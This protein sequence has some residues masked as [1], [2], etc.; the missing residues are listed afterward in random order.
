MK[1]AI[2][3]KIKIPE[4]VNISVHGNEV[5]VKGN[6]GEIKKKLSLKNVEMKVE[7]DEFHCWS[8]K[9][10]KNEKKIVNTNIAHIKNMI[11]GVQEPY[12]YT[13]KIC[14]S[15]FPMTVEVKGTEV[16]LKNYLGEKY[17]RKTQIP[18]G[19]DVKVNKDTITVT[20]PDKELAGQTAAVFERM[21]SVGKR[22]RRIFQDGIYMI[23][24]AG[25]EI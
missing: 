24:K 4:G 7:G 20:S 2:S 13:L 23:N 21:T 10:T 3:K 16:V 18:Q 17:P 22:D 8:E 15:H 19:V 12:E 25:K 6:S 14:F 1:K 11:K 9:G 5:I